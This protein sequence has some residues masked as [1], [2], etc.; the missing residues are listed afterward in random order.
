MVANQKAVGTVADKTIGI[1]QFSTAIEEIIERVGAGVGDAI[2]RSLE[3]AL[4]FGEDKWKENAKSVLSFSYSR[5]GWGKIRAANGI[6]T[7]KSGPRKGQVKHIRWFGKIYRTGK[8]QRSI[9]HQITE[10]GGDA[11]SGEIG[12]KSM[13]GLAHL[14]EKGH[15]LVGGGS[16]RAFRHIAPAADDAFD[17]FEKVLGDAVQEALDDA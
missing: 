13:P 8:Y 15:A 5:G 14:L 4:Q 16:T 3:D 2:P 12:S 17:R 9:S 11:V 10:R 1:D 7:Y 6:Q